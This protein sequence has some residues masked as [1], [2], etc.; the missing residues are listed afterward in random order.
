MTFYKYWA[1]L[2]SFSLEYSNMNESNIDILTKFTISLLLRLALWLFFISLLVRPDRQI[3]L[4]LPG[5]VWALKSYYFHDFYRFP[6]TASSFFLVSWEEKL[7]RRDCN[8]RRNKQAEKGYLP[9]LHASHILTHPDNA[10]WKGTI[11]K[12]WKRGVGRW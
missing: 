12:N 1:V 6:A 4:Y 11:T 9:C 3:S 8:C 5:N 10:D 2:T 7:L